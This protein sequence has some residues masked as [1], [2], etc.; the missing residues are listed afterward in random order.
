MLLVTNSLIVSVEVH[1]FIYAIKFAIKIYLQKAKLN[2]NIAGK[3]S[4]GKLNL[5]VLVSV[6]AFV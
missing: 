6:V 4:E 3:K 5:T 1:R 2:L